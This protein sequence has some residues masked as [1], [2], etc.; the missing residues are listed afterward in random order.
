[1]RCYQFLFEQ[2]QIV[3]FF[4]FSSNKLTLITFTDFNL[5]LT[6]ILDQTFLSFLD[7]RMLGSPLISRTVEGIDNENRLDP[8]DSHASSGNFGGKTLELN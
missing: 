2:T 7:L 1:M 5:G 8:R 6:C 3:C 4:V